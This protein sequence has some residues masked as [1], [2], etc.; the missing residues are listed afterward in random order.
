MRYT[1]T[2]ILKFF[3]LIE[4]LIVVAII[5]IL[6]GMLLPALKNSRDKVKAISC[7]NNQ[8]QTGLAVLSYMSDYPNYFSSSN[9]NRWTSTL[10]NN[11]Y[12]KNGNI[13]CCPSIEKYDRYSKTSSGWYAY[14]AVYTNDASGCIPMSNTAPYVQTPSRAYVF[15]CSWSVSLQAPVFKMYAWDGST[16]A[17]GRPYLVHSN[18]ANMYFFDGHAS[19]CSPRM[20]SDAAGY[21]AIRF[22][23][24]KSGSIYLQIK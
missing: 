9:S 8:K 4:L 19:S 5:A 10:V 20:L 17:Y 24:E 6:A 23:A 21:K 16:E 22:V 15:G 13:L 14:G 18:T 2:G 12:I 7:L 11:G 1:R 3:T